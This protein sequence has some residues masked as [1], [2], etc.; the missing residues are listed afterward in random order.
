MSGKYYWDS[1]DLASITGESSSYSYKKDTD[2]SVTLFESFPGQKQANLPGYKTYTSDDTSEPPFYDD[3]GV[4]VFRNIQV[5]SSSST[6]ISNSHASFTTP[7]WANAC[8]IYIRSKKG[9]DGATASGID[10]SNTNTRNNDDRN[11]IENENHNDNGVFNRNTRNNNNNRNDN[12]HN[13]HNAKWSAQSDFTGGKGGSGQVYSTSKAFSLV[14]GDNEFTVQYK[15]NS[16][17]SDC[18]I[19]SG[20]TIKAQ[21][22]LTNGGNGTDATASSETINRYITAYNDDRRN[23]RGNDY[24]TD[25][26]NVGLGGD[27]G[28]RHD[29]NPKNFEFYFKPNTNSHPNTNLTNAWPNYEHTTNIASVFNHNTVSGGKELLYEADWSQNELKLVS[30]SD[31]SNGGDGTKQTETTFNNYSSTN[32]TSTSTTQK[33]TVYW[34]KI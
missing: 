26:N 30:G 21:V 2:S 18:R 7:D 8:K 10:A 33:I 12:R 9:S 16:S 29:R 11:Y 14:S 28:Q 20:G 27:A 23:T 4:S 31:G 5:A 19:M 17:G 32:N 6:T 1:V 24:N 34:F 25:A 3:N 22:I 13:N 15:L